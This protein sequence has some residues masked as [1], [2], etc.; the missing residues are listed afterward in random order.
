MIAPAHHIQPEPPSVAGAV[1]GGWV[2]GAGCDVAAVADAPPGE[3]GGAA[4]GAA[5]AAAEA[6]AAATG[7]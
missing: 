2:E 3:A 7:P 5:P 4:D 1:D 6:G